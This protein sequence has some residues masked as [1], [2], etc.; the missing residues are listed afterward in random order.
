METTEGRSASASSLLA[1]DDIG[2]LTIKEY[3][4]QIIFFT[5]VGSPSKENPGFHPRAEPEES[6]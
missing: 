1:N 2:K 5:L 3:R 6:W 4:G